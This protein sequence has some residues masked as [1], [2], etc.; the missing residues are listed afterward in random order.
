VY[1]NGVLKRI[2]TENGYY[3]NGNYYFYVKNHQ[4]SN[5]VVANRNGNV[6][7]QTHYYPFGL[8]MSIS[9]GQGA[10]P[11]K[12]TGKEL[13]MEHGLMQYDF[14][15]RQYDP[16]VGRFMTMD[17]LAEKY[18]SVSPYAYCA[19]NPVRYI[20]PNGM[21]YTYNWNTGN[22][23]DEDGNIISWGAS[24]IIGLLMLHIL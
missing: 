1:E 9:D 19:N 21:S 17:P 14:E 7:Q 8:T 22:Y 12:Y 11:Y 4:G 24:F 10:Q 20:D 6:V 16:T 2:L 5:V 13:D 3:E 18:Y 23:E 15:A